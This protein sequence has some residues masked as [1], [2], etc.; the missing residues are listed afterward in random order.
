MSNFS[1]ALLVTTLAGLSTAIGSIISLAFHKPSD[2]FMTFVLGFSAGVMIL[3]SFVELLQAGIDRIGFLS[4]HIAFFAGIAVMFLIDILV[5]HSF[6]GESTDGSSGKSEKLLRMGL[7]VA[8]GIGIHNFPE[9]IG[10]FI[11]AL[12]DPKLGTAIAVAI[13]IHNIPEGIAVAAPIY[14]AT[15]DRRK[16]FLWSALSGLAEPVGALLAAAVL[17]PIL[18]E[19]VLAIALALVAGIMIYISLDELVP[20]A[21]AFGYEHL[22]IAGTALGMMVMAASL[23]LLR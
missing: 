22:A 23:E 15:G 5:P 19:T 12:S 6:G 3:V 20:A 16:A 4:G 11:G 13:A 7:F 9:G 2:K 1:I 10:V 14:A 18:N 17:M 21:R 8:L